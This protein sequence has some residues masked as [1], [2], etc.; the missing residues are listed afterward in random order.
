MNIKIILISAALIGSQ[1][2]FA[3]EHHAAPPASQELNFM[4]SLTGSWEGL[5]KM[6]SDKAE[7]TR[8][9]YKP[10]SGG[11]AVIETLAPDTSHEMTTMYHQ[12]GNSM[13]LTHYCSM[14]N[15]PYMKLK[16]ATA[17]SLSFEI[18]DEMGLQSKNEMHMHALK[19]TL[20]DSNTLVQEWTNYVNGKAT[21]TTTLNFKR[22][23][24]K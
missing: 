14:G 20:K 15:Q 19:L 23:Q 5:N 16:Q 1:F 24:T 10:T 17:N 11:T 18:V 3:K 13:A 12:S 2:V 4:T 9:T 21:P 8:V 22:Q 7:L 6:G